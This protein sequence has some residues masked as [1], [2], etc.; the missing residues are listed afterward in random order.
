MY[1]EADR[2]AYPIYLL[3]NVATIGVFFLVS[4]LGAALRRVARPGSGRD[5]MASLFVMGGAITVA[6]QL[7]LIGTNQTATFGYCDCGNLAEELIAQSKTLQLGFAVQAWLAIGGLAIVGLGAAAAGWA[8]NVSS[9]WRWLSF[10]IAALLIVAATLL[11]IDQLALSDLAG[12]LAGAILVPLWALLLV[13]ALPRLA[14][15]PP[16]TTATG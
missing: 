2:H 1:R 11:V 15:S 13:R 16:P 12:G 6:S 9:T 5:V 3:S 10:A 14:K 7:V 8:V 4:N